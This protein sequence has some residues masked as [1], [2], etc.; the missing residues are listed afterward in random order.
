MKNEDES[1]R[2]AQR[3]GETKGVGWRKGRSEERDGESGH[4]GGVS[5]VLAKCGL[6]AKYPEDPLDVTVTMCSLL[7]RG[8]RPFI[9]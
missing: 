8:L 7:S 1:A 3:D 9:N 2:R 6:E 4:K 5:I